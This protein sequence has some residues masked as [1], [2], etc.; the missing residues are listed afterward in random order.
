MWN[1]MRWFRLRHRSF[2]DRELSVSTAPPEETEEVAVRSSPPRLRD[3]PAA[4]VNVP[5]LVLVPAMYG[6]VQRHIAF[7]QVDRSGVIEGDID[8][9]LRRFRC[10]K[11]S[12]FPGC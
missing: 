11:W 5:L 2:L 4:A 1:R 7:D 8:F 6:D 9:G 12:R 3:V 10:R